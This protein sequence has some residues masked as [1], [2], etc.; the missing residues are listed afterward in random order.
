M[1]KLFRNIR[2]KLLNEGRTS[3]YLTYAVGEII[4]VVIGILIALSINTW[5]Q[6][7]QACLKEEGY[8]INLER[9][10]NNQISSIDIQLSYEK[11]FADAGNPLL[12]E[13][14]ATGSL[15]IDSASSAKLREL[16]SRKTFIRTDPTYEDLISTG[17]I[18]LIRD[19]ELRNALI[20]YYQ[21]L[22]RYEKILQ[23]NNSLLVDEMFAQEIVKL[24]YIG[25]SYTKDIFEFSNELLQDKERRM[26][27]L[28]IIDFRTGIA[29]LHTEFMNELRIKTST[30]LA[31]L[32]QHRQ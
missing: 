23:N 14:N 17:N 22:E 25:N 11:I 30:I 6:E 2:Q 31:Q 9:D 15:K 28:N 26:K 27:L 32:K 1:I 19:S 24:I 13:F 4:L 21:E 20:E 18:G 8:L 7:R 3:K 16:C 29:E 10:L 5:N 12:E